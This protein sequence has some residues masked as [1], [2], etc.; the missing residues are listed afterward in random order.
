MFLYTSTLINNIH[1]FASGLC[2]NSR[3][4]LNDQLCIQG[5]CRITCNSNN[6]CPDFQFC[7]NRICSKDIQ[8][9]SNDD[10]A[11]GEQCTIGRNGIPQCVDVCE[12]LPCGR[13]ATCIGKSHQAT[14]SCKRG[15]FG[16]P[17]TGCKR[18]ECNSDAECSDDKLC[19]KNMCKIACL[20]S[21]DCRDNTICSS[22]KHK[23]VCYCQP[24]YTGDPV[25]GCTQIN[26]CSSNPCGNGAE[27]KNARNRAQCACPAGTVGNPYEEG[28]RKAQEC[29]FNRDCPAVA[30]CTV[31]D[32]IRK[33]T[34]KYMWLH[35]YM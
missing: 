25:K 14:C 12:K 20:V 2:K 13:Q 26:W 1:I 11:D 24:G 10:C 4:C 31:V 17:L 15:F 6:T 27:C 35:R 33:C 7:L 30:R 3:D 8:C 28:C 34:G 23:H 22:E 9:V 29:R 32:G 19:E 5:T 16:D 18:K 21:N